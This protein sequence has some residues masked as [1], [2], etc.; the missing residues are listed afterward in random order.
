MVIWCTEKSWIIIGIDRLTHVDTSYCR[1][2][3][4][5]PARWCGLWRRVASNTL[6]GCP[7]HR[8][9]S[10]FPW[11]MSGMSLV[12]RYWRLYR[13]SHISFWRTRKIKRW[14]SVLYVCLMFFGSCFVHFLGHATFLWNTFPRNY[15]IEYL[16]VPG[17][18]GGFDRKQFPQR[19]A[20]QRRGV[21][22]SQ[23]VFTQMKVDDP[24]PFGAVTWQQAEPTKRAHEMD[25]TAILGNSVP[26]GSNWNTSS[27]KTDVRLWG[28]HFRVN[29]QYDWHREAPVLLWQLGS[30]VECK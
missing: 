8:L 23:H 1:I 3:P 30:L 20:L 9:L 2:L 4:S 22:V 25:A 6:V 21:V 18:S 24:K 5:S 13:P 19:L 15:F 17:M 29:L 10:A 26:K 28:P 14:W 27:R 7:H 11:C 12:P 16:S